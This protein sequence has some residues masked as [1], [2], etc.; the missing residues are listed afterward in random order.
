M[1]GVDRKRAAKRKS[2]KR[3]Y[4]RAIARWDNE[5]G[6]P[7]SPAQEIRERRA[8]LAADEERILRCLGGALIMQWNDLP[9]GIQRSLFEYAVSMGEPR[10]TVVLK[11][12]IARFLHTHKRGWQS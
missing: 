6:A 1:K 10:E 2:A 12:R 5:G 7:K 3:Q 9:R 8:A 11:A 4:A